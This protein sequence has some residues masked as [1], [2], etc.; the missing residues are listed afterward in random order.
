MSLETGQERHSTFRLWV[1]DHIDFTKSCKREAAKI[2]NIKEDL[3]L[4]CLTISEEGILDFLTHISNQTGAFAPQTLADTLG[5]PNRDSV[6][7]SKSIQSDLKLLLDYLVLNEHLQV[8]KD[9]K[10]SNVK[11]KVP[12]TSKSNINNQVLIA[13]NEMLKAKI[14]HLESKLESRGKAGR[15]A[16]VMTKHGVIFFEKH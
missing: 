4:T 7:K 12:S 13:E 1:Y 8:P 10:G 2:K 14:A 5:F 9:K 15:L 16:D 11:G 3:D 6:R